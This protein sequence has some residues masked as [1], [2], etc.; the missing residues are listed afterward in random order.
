MFEDSAVEAAFLK[1]RIPH[2]ALSVGTALLLIV[3]TALLGLWND[4]RYGA[5]GSEAAGRRLPLSVAVGYTAGAQ[6]LCAVLIA[7]LRWRYG[8]SVCRRPPTPLLA[9]Y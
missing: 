9:D 3:G 7:L 8:G 5:L 2:A 4:S 1:I 6:A